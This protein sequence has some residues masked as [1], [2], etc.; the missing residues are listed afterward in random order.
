MDYS[1]KFFRMAVRFLGATRMDL[2]EL[3]DQIRSLGYT[4]TAQPPPRGFKTQIGVSGVVAAK[5]GV[6]ID[7]DTDRLIV[8]VS[9]PEPAECIDEFLALEK[10]VASSFDSLKG[11]YFYELLVELEIKCS[12][13]EPMEFLQRVSKGIIIAEKMSSALGEQLFVFGYRLAREGTSPEDSEWVDVEIIP[14]L[15]R[16]HSSMYI[17]IVY[18]SKD[19]EKVIE[20]SK[21]LDVLVKT[22]NELMSVSRES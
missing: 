5:G 12:N 9:S 18:R 10:L 8:G 6:A 7:V 15:I 20:K 2:H 16:A 19:L 11:A 3:L 17:S 4:I 14:Y 1:V 13:F 21:N 22:L